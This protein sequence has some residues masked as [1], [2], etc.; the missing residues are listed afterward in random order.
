MILTGR[1]LKALCAAVMIQLDVP[2]PAV[3]K[4]RL[5]AQEQALAEH[6]DAK[7]IAALHSLEPA[8]PRQSPGWLDLLL[9]GQSDVVLSTD[10]VRVIVRIADVCLT[11]LPVNDRDFAIFVGLPEG[12]IDSLRTAHRKLIASLDDHA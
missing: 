2:F 3:D 11:I 6:A 7:L 4:P 1:E 8:L 10:E 5:S 12:G 9:D